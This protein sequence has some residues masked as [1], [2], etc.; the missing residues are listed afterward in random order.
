MSEPDSKY[1]ARLLLPE[2]AA[3]LGVTVAQLENKP[4]DIQIMLAQTYV[5]CWHSDNC[6]I[7]KALEQDLYVDDKEP[8]TENQETIKQK[9]HEM[10]RTR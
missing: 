8:E 3:V 2:I 6:S 9:N 4:I 10:E 1:Y 7:K 5:N